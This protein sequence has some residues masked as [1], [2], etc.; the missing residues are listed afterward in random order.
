MIGRAS[1]QITCCAQI[2]SHFKL[3]EQQILLSLRGF[4]LTP[5]TPLTLLRDGDIVV[6][7]VN[8]KLEVTYCLLG[9]S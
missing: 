7:S 9:C 6:V 4:G 8:N 3:N 2:I 5:D 1:A